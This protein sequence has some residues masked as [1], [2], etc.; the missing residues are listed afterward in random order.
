MTVSLVEASLSENQINCHKNY[1]TTSEA[2]VPSGRSSS[3]RVGHSNK[4]KH[5]TPF[6]AAYLLFGLLHELSHIVVARSVAFA[7]WLANN[8]A[9]II[10]SSIFAKS[11]PKI[12]DVAIHATQFIMRALLG[13]YCLVDFPIVREASP[14]ANQLMKGI[15]LHSGWIF[16]WILAC[17]CHY[18]YAVSNRRTRNTRNVTHAHQSPKDRIMNS[19]QSI[20]S[21][22]IIIIAA[23]VTAIEATSTDLFGFIPHHDVTISDDDDEGSKE[24]YDRLVFFCGNF[25]I[26][27]INSSWINID[28][29]KNALNMLEKM[30][31]VTMMRGKINHCVAYYLNCSFMSSH[32]LP[33]NINH[34]I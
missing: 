5:Y 17:V 4:Y 34:L 8:D 29:G 13:R 28:G 19:I 12:D 31:N 11:F 30:V 32:M 10:I 15:I 9:P 14:Q 6:I 2:I 18:L 7:W 33:N 24:M 21:E 16:S 1:D 23:Y 3:N 25:G 26:I 22:P 27:L 20:L